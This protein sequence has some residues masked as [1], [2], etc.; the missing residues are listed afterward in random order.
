MFVPAKN[1]AYIYSFPLSV[2]T[3]LD[4]SYLTS[5]GTQAVRFVRLIHTF[6]CSPVH[7]YLISVLLTEDS[8]TFE[9]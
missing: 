3:V 5:L 2:Y 9:I 1:L 6:L 8:L 4:V 7:N